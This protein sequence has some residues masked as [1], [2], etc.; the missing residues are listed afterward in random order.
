MEN[1]RDTVKIIKSIIKFRKKSLWFL[2][3]WKFPKSIRI[4]MNLRTVASPSLHTCF[5]PLNEVTVFFRNLTKNIEGI[6]L[7]N[8]S[9]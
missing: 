4:F 2:E 9:S 5:N 8:E 6:Y 3:Y 7:T 1:G